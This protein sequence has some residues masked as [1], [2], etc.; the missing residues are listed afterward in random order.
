MRFGLYLVSTL[1]I[2]AA[3]GQ[4]DGPVSEV[5]SAVTQSPAAYSEADIL[6]PLP[7][8][9]SAAITQA[10]LATRIET[11]SSDVFEGRAP[12]TEAGEASAKW[13]AADMQRIGLKPGGD[14]DSYMQEVAM[15]EL[16][17]DETVSHFTLHKEDTAKALRLG[18]EAVIW[19]KRQTEAVMDFADS[20][21]V[22]VGYGVVAPE[23]GWND[24]AGLDVEG[25]TVVMLVN[26]PGYANP[27][28]ALFKGRAM[29]YYGRWTYKYEEAARQGAKAAFVIHE[30]APASYGWDVVSNSWS[31]AQADLIRANQGEDR[32]LMEGWLSHDAAKSLFQEA[33]LD[34]DMQKAAAGQPGFTPVDMGELTA[35][36]KIAQSLQSGKISQ[37]VIGVLEGQ[38]KPDEYMLYVGHWDHLGKKEPSDDR[39]ATED[40]IYN[41]AVDN[42]TGIAAILEIAEAMQA[43]T[44]DRSVLF[45][46]VTLEESGLLGS[47]YYAET[48]TI[49]LNKI[50]AGLN[51]D[52]MLPIGKTRDMIVVGYGASELEDRLAV[53]AEA[54]DRVILPDPTPEA[55]YFYRSDHI[56]FAKKGVPML[57]ADAGIDKL[58]GGVEAGTAFSDSYRVERYHQPADEY[59]ADW[60]LSGMV[61]EVQ[62][63]FTLGLNIANTEKWPEWYEGNEFK[64]I[65][66]ASLT[67]E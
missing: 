39:D 22:F 14:N 4:A 44:L 63:F 7:L 52:A 42:A 56:S 46:A 33:G 16:T 38:T 67:E 55:G 19:S 25:K 59:S 3:C 2:S 10:D 15:V 58:D 20:E 32:I 18:E 12:G 62:T 61:Q 17:L 13:I 47:A 24:Y 8:D 30:T 45:V 27:D 23:Y 53:I 29:T 51:I 48:P 60:D 11:L 41:G 31:G 6:L 57:Y 21:I 37:N 36:G 9:T 5:E 49:P 54:D 28:G 50:V 35:S 34:Y 43:E 66:D 64:A 65:R 40:L 1:L 26:D